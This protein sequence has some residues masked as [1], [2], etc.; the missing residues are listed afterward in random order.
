[1]PPRTNRN[2][3]NGKR[4]IWGAY[5]PDIQRSYPDM[6]I[7]GYITKGKYGQ[8]F[9]PVESEPKPKHSRKMEIQYWITGDSYDLVVQK[10]RETAD[11]AIKELKAGIQRLE[12]FIDNN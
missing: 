3:M 4:A 2:A 12:R 11:E 5:I 10:M 6:P 8:V 1:M 9:M 7:R